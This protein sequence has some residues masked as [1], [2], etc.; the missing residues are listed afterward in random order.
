MVLLLAVSGKTC[1]GCVMHHGLTGSIFSSPA[2]GL[3]RRSS[4]LAAEATLVRGRPQRQ[5]CARG[6]SNLDIRPPSPMARRDHLDQRWS[7]SCGLRSA[8]AAADARDGKRTPSL[9]DF[10]SGAGARQRLRF[11]LPSGGAILSGPLRAPMQAPGAAASAGC[12]RSAIV[13]RSCRLRA[14]HSDRS[15]RETSAA[16]RSATGRPRLP[17]VSS[18]GCSWTSRVVHL[19]PAA[20]ARY[21]QRLPAR[22]AHYWLN[23]WPHR[24]LGS[25]TGASGRPASP[26][27]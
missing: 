13:S 2:G 9:G 19:L 7:V 27:R 1:I 23:T 17:E 25:T 11:P 24:L 21:L 6:S 18:A 20:A 5:R 14:L 26:P 3:P 4:S 16:A 12:D 15:G 8:R 10:E 22:R